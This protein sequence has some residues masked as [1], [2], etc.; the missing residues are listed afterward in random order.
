MPT[1][2][3]QT[4]ANRSLELCIAR[5]T[6]TTDRLRVQ[7]IKETRASFQK[8]EPVSQQTHLELSYSWDET[9]AYLGLVVFSQC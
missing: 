5:G 3:I 2:A 6:E 9:K 4:R 8:I 1:I 7:K